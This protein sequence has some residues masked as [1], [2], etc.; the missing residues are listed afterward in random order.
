MKYVLHFFYK[1]GLLLTWILACIATFLSLYFGEFKHVLPCTLC[2]YLRIT[3][4][5][6]VIILAKAVWRNEKMIISYV[7]PLTLLGLLISLWLLIVQR[8]PSLLVGCQ[9]H[10]CLVHH[11]FIGPVTMALAAFIGMIIINLTLLL[12]RISVKA[13][14]KS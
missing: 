12:T 5:P 14:Y 8:F 13:P 3:V 4:F 9:D 6:L 7:F 1:Y 2:W 11:T 10:L